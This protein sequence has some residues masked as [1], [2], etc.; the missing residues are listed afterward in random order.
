MPKIDI[1]FP[2]IGVPLGIWLAGVLLKHRL[3]L[4]F[5]FFFSYIAV[6]IVGEAIGLAVVRDYAI[7]Y[8]VF[9]TFEVICAILALAAL[10][11]AFY[12]VFR[13]FFHKYAWFWLLFPSAVLLVVAFAALYAILRPP[14]QAARI[15][16]LILSLEIGINLIQSCI[17]LL[18]QG[19]MWFFRA[20]RRNYPLGI[21]NGFA[22]VA[23]AGLLYAL[24]SEFGTKFTLLVQYGVPVAYIVAEIVWL[25]A[26]LRP[27]EPAP[28]LPRG[29]TLEQALDEMTRDTEWVKDLSRKLRR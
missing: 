9:W 29:I 5:P 26:F 11:E 17:F 7:Y 14:A 2:V 6:T 4:E 18:F 19:A 27:P 12:R 10:H 1:L 13:S 23:L 21:V 24:R 25:A 20:R 22:I 16:S 3:H 15:T 28:Q 8:Y